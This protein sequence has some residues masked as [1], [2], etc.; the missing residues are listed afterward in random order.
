MLDLI[1][2]KK[3]RGEAGL[4]EPHLLGHFCSTEMQPLFLE[5]TDLSIG[6]CV[7]QGCVVLNRDE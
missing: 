2:F 3:K 1:G 4:A 5:E 7:K 6:P